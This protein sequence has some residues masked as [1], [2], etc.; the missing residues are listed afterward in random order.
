MIQRLNH[1]YIQKENREDTKEK[2]SQIGDK[3]LFIGI[4][5]KNHLHYS[6]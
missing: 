2:D 5:E 4:T 3:I 1:I 6:Y